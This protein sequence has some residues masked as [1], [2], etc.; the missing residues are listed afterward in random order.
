M[1]VSDARQLPKDARIEADLCIV[2][3]GAAGIAMAK[4]LRGS[5]LQVALLESGGLGFEHRTQFLYLGQRTGQ[6]NFSTVHSRFRLFGGSTTRWGG[7]C[8]PFDA[9][10]FERRDGVPW[11]GWPFGP[12]ELTPRY[13]EASA[14]CNL[15]DADFRPER[16]VSRASPMLPIESDWLRS[17]IFQFSHPRDFGV[18][19]RSALFEAHDIAVWLHANVV[20]L[21]T[22]TSG[23]HVRSALVRTLNGRSAVVNARAF[24]LACGGIEN[25]RILLASDRQQPGGLGN[26]NDLVGRFFMDHPYCVAGHFE[27]ASE[28]FDQT[29]YAIEDYERAGPEQKANAAF[30]LH[31]HVVRGEQLNNCGLYFVRRAAYKTDPPY[32]S[33]GGRSFAH[34]VDVLRHREVP[35]RRFARHLLNIATGLGDIGQV[36]RAQARQSL[37]PRSCLALRAIVEA[38]PNRDSRIT[39]TGR[40][41]ALGMPRVRVDWQVN[42]A[43]R[44]G[45]A[46]LLECVGTEVERLALGRLVLHPVN[47][48]E[49]WPDGTFGGKHHMGTTRMHEDPREGVVDPHCRVHGLA[50]LYIAG[51]SVFPTG[52]AVNPTLTLVALALRLAEHVRT[53]LGGVRSRSADTRHEAP[54]RC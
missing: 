34:L 43:D 29:L 3:A 6:E 14:V 50:N 20:E 26:R 51:S 49:R 10:D 41:D 17:V 32:F 33:P 47:F 24:I 45:L 52:G 21:Q 1:S 35:D 23:S 46:R 53:E 13:R 9:V 39:L 4:A 54:A 7:Q 15:S 11:S 19:Y 40:R 18:H 30:S 28:A 38:T 37:R 12:D 27:P 42:P 8:R 48:R 44:R 16:W 22:D 5:G 25:A 36:L 2:G 31:E